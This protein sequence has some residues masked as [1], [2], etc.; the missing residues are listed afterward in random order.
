MATGPA[1]SPPYRL[2]SAAVGSGSTFSAQKGAS[3]SQ[4]GIQPAC[5][6][7]HFGSKVRRFLLAF[8][9][10]L[11][12]NGEALCS[13]I[14]KVRVK[15]RELEHCDDPIDAFVCQWMSEQ[16]ERLDHLSTFTSA[17]SHETKCNHSHV[18]KRRV[19]AVS[20]RYL[21]PYR[22]PLSPKPSPRRLPV[23]SPA[24]SKCK[25]SVKPRPRT[26]PRLSLTV[27][28]L[29]DICGDQ[30]QHPLQLISVSGYVDS[31]VDLARQECFS[32]WSWIGTL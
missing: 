11:C 2:E 32:G 22:Q 14:D 5:R 27:D 15:V 10:A 6:L 8:A 29:I 9:L 1:R 18:G 28:A 7:A 24:L 26:H 19:L 25:V 4:L 17:N 13:L 12:Y 3:K 21:G 30:I 20:W 23:S 16:G 31:P